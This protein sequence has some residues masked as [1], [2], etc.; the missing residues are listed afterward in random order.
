M[1]L[2]NTALAISETE[3]E[4]V[5]LHLYWNTEL[6]TLIFGVHIEIVLIV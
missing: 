6:L 1:F 5:I 4:I 2:K 3:G